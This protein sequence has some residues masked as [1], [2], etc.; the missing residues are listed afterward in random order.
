MEISS[1]LYV[2]AHFTSE[3]VFTN[4]SENRF[5]IY[6]AQFQSGR[7]SRLLAS[8]TMELDRWLFDVLTINLVT[9]DD[10]TVPVDMRIDRVRVSGDINSN[11]DIEVRRDLVSVSG[12][13]RGQNGAVE[14]TMTDLGADTS[15]AAAQTESTMEVNINLRMSVGQRMQVHLSTAQGDSG[16]A[17]RGL[18]APGTELRLLMDSFTAALDIQGDVALRGGEIVYLNRNFYL[19]EG[20]IVFNETMGIFDPRITVRAETRERDTEGIQVRIIMTALNQPLSEFFPAFTSS[21]ARSEAEIMHILGRIVTADS[22]SL[23]DFAFAMLDYGVQLAVLRKIET[24]LRELLNFDIFS[25]RTMILQNV[26][27]S[28][29]DSARQDKPITAGS[30]FDNST[31]YAGKYFGSSIYADA[32][33]HLSYDENE[34][35]SGKSET[36]IVFQPEFGLEM[37]SPYVTIRWSIAPELGKTDFLWVDATSITLSWKFSF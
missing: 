27:R 18:V 25:M 33:L 35:L 16:V 28:V 32:L 8:L 2:P 21:P 31:I 15:P 11:L 30:V 12:N 10:I 37:L 4:V 26:L 6:D 14:V 19:R 34:V 22:D 17:V 29:S 24:G 3:Y 23:G 7:A 5:E 9:P 36:G 13:V 20:R 1:P